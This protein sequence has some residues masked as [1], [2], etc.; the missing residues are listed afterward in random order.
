MSATVFFFYK[1]PVFIC[2]AADRQTKKK[3]IDEQTDV[4][5]YP[6]YY[7]VSTDKFIPYICTYYMDYITLIH[8]PDTHNS[9]QFSLL[10]FVN[11]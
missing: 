10:Y 11:K 1:A 9:V 3:L 6:V 2:W 7:I 4:N 8:F 5:V